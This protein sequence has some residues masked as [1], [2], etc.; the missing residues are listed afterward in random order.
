MPVFRIWTVLYLLCLVA[1]SMCVNDIEYEGNYADIYDNEISQDQQEGEVHL[2][3]WLFVSLVS[4]L[5][6]HCRKLSL[7]VK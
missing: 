2:F 1:A 7:L 5:F 3:V 4:C 6:E